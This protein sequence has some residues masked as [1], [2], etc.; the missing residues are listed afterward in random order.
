MKIFQDKG[1]TL[2]P[3]V[4]TIFLLSRLLIVVGAVWVFFLSDLGLQGRMLVGIL[5]CSFIIQLLLLS[6]LIRK[7]KSDLKKAYL[8]LMLF[9][10]VF[11]SVLIHFS[12]GYHSDFYLFYYLIVA[13]SSYVLVFRFSM[14]INM[15]VTIVYLAL[16]MQHISNQDAVSILLRIGLMWFLS[17][18]ISFVSDYIRRSERR[19]L[20]L[21]DTL[22]QRTAE[23]E[24]SQAHLEL[25]YEN[26]RVL[27]GILEVDGVT[28]EVMRILGEILAYPACG[29]LLVGPGDNLI[30]RGRNIGGQLNFH[31]KAA[32]GSKSELIRRVVEQAEPVT[33]VDITERKDYQPLRSNSRAVMLVPMIAHGKILGVLS[34]ESPEFAAFTNKDE[35]ML[36]V[37]A[38]SAAL[39]LDNAMLHRKMEELTIT[40]EL[41]GIYNYR[42]FTQKLKE[43]Q[44]R[45]ARYDQP[46]S[47]IMLDIDWFKKFNDTYGHEVGNIVL[48]GITLVVKQCIRDVDIFAR[49]GG[50]EF[51][52]LLPQT[53]KAE[54]AR[55]G[56]RI[57]Q[58][59]EASRFDG[60]DS[61]P[62][63]TVTV[64]IGVTS[65]PEN[66]KPYDE[67]LSV[68][69]QALYRAKGAG[70]NLVC[71]I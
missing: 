16:T 35:N 14:I 2:L 40:D 37:V 33:V 39:A 22:N 32:D 10:L 36:A 18:A 56:E 48:E 46:L 5:T 25:I 26:T 70:K 7:K 9:D 51:V 34:A 27:A 44:R 50:E 67:L 63:L 55:I 11:I 29:L 60:G 64:S 71:V 24:K 69:D 3:R 21:F 8:S 66:G 61:I 20:K 12:G 17:L 52:V 57:R 43:E 19:L 68:A 1:K 42:Y 54:A 58:Q 49:Y 47:M 28:E 13:F 4:D 65:Y 45:A 53:P 59:I 41:T 23:L 38:R 62:D 15:I 30:Y 31:L 6:H